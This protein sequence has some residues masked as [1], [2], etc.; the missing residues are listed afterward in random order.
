MWAG[1]SVGIATELRA[2]RSEVRIPVGRDFP[3]VQTCPGA[4]PASYTTGTGSLPAV[5]Y[6]RG[7]LLTTH[8]LLVPWSWKSGAVPLPTLW[9]TIGPATGTLY[10]FFTLRSGRSG[11]RTPVGSEIFLALRTVLQSDPTFNTMGTVSFQGVKLPGFAF[12]SQPHPTPRVK[13]R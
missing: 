9:A 2:G 3:P 12:T 13:G 5:K 4:H 7:V 1:S 8:H 11:F 10:T 6:G